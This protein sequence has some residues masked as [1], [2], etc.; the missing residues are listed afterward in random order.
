MFSDLNEYNLSLALYRWGLQTSCC[1]FLFFFFII[2]E[3]LCVCS[4]GVRR[5]GEEEESKGPSGFRLPEVHVERRQQ[6]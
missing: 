6:R 3:C 2:T 5:G 4:G 1:Q